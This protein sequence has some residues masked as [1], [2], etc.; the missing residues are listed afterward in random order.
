[1]PPRITTVRQMASIL[2]A[3]H[4]RPATPVGACWVSRFINRHEDLKSKYNCKYDYQQAKCE[5]PILIQSWF[6]RVQDTIIQ[7][8]ILNKDI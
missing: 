7:Y 6:K 5:D 2:A 3:Q 8:R 1:M 4:A